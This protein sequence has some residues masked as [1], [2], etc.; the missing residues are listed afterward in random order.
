MRFIGCFA[1]WKIVVVKGKKCLEDLMKPLIR[2]YRAAWGDLRLLE[3]AFDSEF[4]RGQLAPGATMS[5][6][7]LVR[8]YLRE[9]WRTELNPT[10]DFDTAFYLKSNPDLAESGA[11]PFVHYLRFGRAEGRQPSGSTSRH[12]V[13]RPF[14]DAGFYREQSPDLSGL[15]D[16]ELVAHYL[17]D[18]WRQGLD[19]NLTFSTQRYLDVND[20]V[21]KR[22]LNPF[23]HYIEA[24]EIEGRDPNPIST[25][26]IELDKIR[27]HFNSD[28]YRARRTDISHYSDENALLHYH[29][30]GW[31]ENSDPCETF[32]VGF[33][34]NRNP[35]VRSKGIDP[36]LHY[37]VTGREEG[38]A[39]RNSPH[40]DWWELSSEEVARLMS[41]FDTEWYLEQIHLGSEGMKAK[42][43][44]D[45][46]AALAH[47]VTTGWRDGYDPGP[48]FSTSEYLKAYPN[49]RGACP[50][51]HF[52][53]HDQPVPRRPRADAP[54][55]LGYSPDHHPLPQFA[56]P[57]PG[58]ESST[59]TQNLAT[60]AV[61]P[62]ES[63]DLH[64]VIPDFAKGGGGHMT[65]FRM[66]RHLEGFGHR[67]T[68]WIDRPTHH[69]TC[70]EAYDDIIRYFQCVAADIRFL[71][72]GFDKATGDAVIATGWATAYPVQ[73]A[74][75]FAR[76]FYFVQDYEPAFY[77]KGS[78]HYLAAQTYEFDLACICASPW[79]EEKLKT[80]HGRWAR[81]F[82]LAYNREVYT[83]RRDTPDFALRLT[84]AGPRHKIA[85]Y[86]RE[87][88]ARRCVQLAVMALAE[89]SQTRD[90]FEVH[91]FGQD[92]LSFQT[93]NFR[94]FNHGVLAETDLAQLYNECDL[95]LCFSGTN[96][97]LVPQEMMACGLPLIELD[98]EST[99]A[100]FPEGVVTL[101]GPDPR[102]IAAKTASLLDT[103]QARA[104]Q[105]R[106]AADWAADFNWESSARK[107]E[108]ALYEGLGG[109]GVVA[110]EIARPRDLIMD[111][112]IPTWNGLGEIENV[113]AALRDQ[114][115]A[116]AIQIHCIDSSS[117]DG[118]T[119]WLRKQS[120][121]AL[122]VIAQSEFQHG[123]TRNLGASLGQAPLIGFLTQ[124]AIPA[125][126]N[127]ADDLARMLQHYP[128]AAGIFGRHIPYPQHCLYVQQEITR[129]FDNIAKK[130]LAVSRTTDPIQWESGHQG[131]RQFLHFYSDNNSAMRR[132]AYDRIPYPEIDYGED[133]V[134][135]RDIIE[136][137]YVKLY[138]PTAAVWH[139]HDYSPDESYT[140][141]KTE[142][143]FFY[144]HF[145]Y[146]LGP[147]T[148][149]ALEAQLKRASTDLAAWGQRNNQKATEV[150][151]QKDIF[152]QKLLGWRDGRL[153]AM[154]RGKK[155]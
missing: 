7:A 117:S 127:W 124:D 83:T 56:F 146:R 46:E 45:P 47:Y 75:G 116:D 54:L 31:R 133:Q 78:E 40:C 104:K 59:S 96:Y 95:A 105:A 94:A 50:L 17:C 90:D 145:G 143:S 150:D 142:G 32:S 26:D 51:V 154:T 141:A 89:L 21:R 129:H 3:T 107:V 20:D 88:T 131:W 15:S 27:P 1:R 91:F 140:R 151:R 122:T 33:Y 136:A 77:P 34:L 22:G 108:A 37:V 13:I 23:V 114:S 92:D 57:M 72:N 30:Q 10:P 149:T 135:A 8:H 80:D 110:P 111:V 67:C 58:D 130:P 102:D 82:H 41:L 138:S 2:K 99:R 49:T 19:P 74:R 61:T 62:P 48:G 43:R 139:S 103:L 98:G 85:V 24:G 14:F 71:E 36:F 86:A 64:W 123:R 148:D 73:A 87:H 144:T 132:S 60:F 44:A 121:V 5:H 65:I 115:I 113:I 28:F 152:Y 125:G 126:T 153:K 16:D 120:D 93:C 68:V 12:A 63:L 97:S 69:N 4:Y 53:L 134:W 155:A 42:L 35:D 76:R 29:T 84:D 11:N 6:R 39:T 118:T 70:E 9:G 128:E 66:I 25:I 100:I 79:L 81:G 106:R 119:D 109:P 18:G 52:L 38:R 112:V 101:A 55:W 137:G 147:D